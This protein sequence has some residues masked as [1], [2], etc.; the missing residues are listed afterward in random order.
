MPLHPYDGPSVGASNHAD[1]SP[2]KTKCQRPE[3]ISVG[4]DHA[5][6]RR[7]TLACSNLDVS[8]RNP[9]VT[10]QHRFTVIN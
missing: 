3:S 2:S 4:P 7:L 9:D 8:D 5:S 1:V 6:G 10:R